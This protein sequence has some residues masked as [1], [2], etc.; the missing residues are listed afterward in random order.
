MK[1]APGLTIVSFTGHGNWRALDFSTVLANA[2]Y[3]S[4][5]ESHG[6]LDQHSRWLIFRLKSQFGVQRFWL[7]ATNRDGLVPNR[8]LIELEPGYSW[9]DVESELLNC[10]AYHFD[11]PRAELQRHLTR[12]VSVDVPSQISPQE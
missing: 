9:S 6:A 10:L 1:T 2:L 8:L 4:E 12:V 5:V 7:L 3:H 11:W